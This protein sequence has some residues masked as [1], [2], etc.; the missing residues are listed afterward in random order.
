MLRAR[1]FQKHPVWS[2]CENFKQDINKW[3]FAKHCGESF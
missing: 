3:F 2:D 1:F